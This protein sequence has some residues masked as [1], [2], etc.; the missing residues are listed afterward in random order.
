MSDLDFKKRDI[1]ILYGDCIERLKELDDNSIDLVFT[2]PPYADKRKNC[3]N[4]TSVNE[5]VK[6]FLPIAKEI[7]RVLSDNGSFFLNLKTHT[8]NGERSLYVFELVIAL[9]NEIGFLFVDE[10]SWIKS[11]YPGHYDGRFKNGFEPVYH[12]TKTL[13]KNITFNPI[14][15]GTKVTEIAIERAK[16]KSTGQPK[17][18][19][20]MSMNHSNI[21]EL[22]LARPSNV[23]KANNVLNQFSLN[24][25]HP[26][27]FPK[28]LVEFF[29]KSYS[30]YGDT[31]LDPFLGS[32]TTGVV[33][34]ELGRK[35]V[36]IEMDE[37]FFNLAK[38]I[39][40][41]SIDLYDDGYEVPLVE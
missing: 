38:Q 18:G 36:G 34:D 41:D 19:S 9:R 33:A 35:F 4:T 15:C 6:W 26:A 1:S 28:Q 22:E 10:L 16:R 32:G 3:Y 40:F 17:S 21:G 29:V 25:S 12:F 8:D 37:E 27:T 11:A 30:N 7:K 24:K 13:P 23:I 5:Y 20:G 39:I 14:A 31:V 2:S